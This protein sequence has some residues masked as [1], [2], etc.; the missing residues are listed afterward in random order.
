MFPVGWTHS[1]P[2]GVS[3]REASDEPFEWLIENHG[4]DGIEGYEEVAGMLVP[5][6][7]G[8]SGD[9]RLEARIRQLG[10]RGLDLSQDTRAYVAAYSRWFQ[11]K[12]RLPPLGT[13]SM[14]EG[15]GLAACERAL[16]LLSPADA[17][18]QE[19]LRQE[20]M[21]DAKRGQ[22]E[23]LASEVDCIEDALASEWY[24]GDVLP[25]TYAAKDGEQVPYRCG[26]ISVDN[27]SYTLTP[28]GKLRARKVAI[29]ASL[30]TLE[31]LGR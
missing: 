30:A 14:D 12:H 16:A 6:A 8:C 4:R 26:P 25:R 5:A 22:R 28:A 10:D 20:A 11:L 19:S 17:S 31:T 29:E 27:F 13:S 7:G 2:L 21:A 15:E 18:R 9:R 24:E 3:L 1:T 23:Q